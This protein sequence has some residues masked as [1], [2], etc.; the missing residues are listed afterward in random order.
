VAC[1]IYSING[2]QV[3]GG[4]WDESRNPVLAAFLRDHTDEWGND[5]DGVVGKTDFIW[6]EEAG[7]RYLDELFED[8]LLT[9]AQLQDGTVSGWLL[10]MID[11]YQASTP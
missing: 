10:F 11:G 2:D 1:D 4:L 5:L 3:Y 9:P 7:F 8:Q 6:T